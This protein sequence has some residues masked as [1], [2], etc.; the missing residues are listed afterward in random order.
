MGLF[1]ILRGQRTP[2]R[3]NLD[4]LFALGNARL[5]LETVAGARADGPGG[6]C[7]KPVEAALFDEVVREPSSSSSWRTRGRPTTSSTDSYGFSWVEV[8]DPDFDDR[9]HGTHLVNQT[10][11]ERGFSEQ[12]LCAVFGFR[13][14]RRPVDFVYVYKRGTFYPFAPRGEQRD[15]A[16]E[17]RLQAALANEIPIEPELE[18]WYPVWDAPVDARGQLTPIGDA[19]RSGSRRDRAPSPRP[20]S[21][22]CAA[23]SARVADPRRRHGRRPR[24][25]RRDQSQLVGGQ[26]IRARAAHPC[27]RCPSANGAAAKARAVVPVSS[28]PKFMGSTKARVEA[29]GALEG[30]HGPLHFGT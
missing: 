28:G 24:G 12:L 11:E 23:C 10:I 8:E 25:H 20:G 2:K 26:H 19:T 22:G 21:G 3:A 29:E 18:R 15:N 5:T 27:G 30:R 17:L 6:V 9:E 14:D 7:F 4:R 16:L 13:G 1:D